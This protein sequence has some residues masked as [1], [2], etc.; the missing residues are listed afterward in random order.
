MNFLS[1]VPQ[2]QAWTGNTPSNI[3]QNVADHDGSVVIQRGTL[4]GL[5]KFT[6]YTVGIVAYNGAG[7]SPRSDTKII[8]TEEGGNYSKRLTGLD[9]YR[10]T[11]FVVYVIVSYLTSIE[12]FCSLNCYCLWVKLLFLDEDCCKM[13]SFYFFFAKLRHVK[14]HLPRMTI[15]WL[16]C[17]RRFEKGLTIIIL[18]FFYSQSQTHRDPLQCPRFTQTPWKWAGTDHW[19]LMAYLSPIWSNI[20]WMIR[21]LVTDIPRHSRIPPCHTR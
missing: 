2:L 7:D 12:L 14:L 21:R 6:Q 1:F 8:K 19:T 18:T 5:K 10:E 4:S 17:N 13:F 3:F 9:C 15:H 11:L 16:K 20:G